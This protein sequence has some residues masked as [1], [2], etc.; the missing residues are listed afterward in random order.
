MIKQPA[1]RLSMTKRIFAVILL[2]VMSGVA[3]TAIGVFGFHKLSDTSDKACTAARQELFCVNIRCLASEQEATVY[4]FLAYKREN[5]TTDAVNGALER[6]YETGLDYLNEYLDASLSSP[7]FGLRDEMQMFDSLWR[8]CHERAV[9]IVSGSPAAEWTAKRSQFTNSIQY[10][11]ERRQAAT[12]NMFLDIE[13]MARN[14]SEIFI[15]MSCIG[16]VMAIIL[17]YFIVAQLQ[18]KLRHIIGELLAASGQ[19]HALANDSGNAALAAVSASIADAAEDLSLLLDGNERPRKPA[20]NKETQ[21][22]AIARQYEA[23]SGL[24]A[25]V[26][27]A[28]LI[29]ARRLS[30]DKGD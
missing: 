8:E 21:T 25:D 23:W 26:R 11:A 15:L 14:I 27:A 24:P 30:E 7:S 2:L 5:D 3:N 17:A 16:T 6:I 18:K 1:L 12:Q 20:G 9:A 4:G 22:D 29:L 28:L 13:M 19:A 10:L